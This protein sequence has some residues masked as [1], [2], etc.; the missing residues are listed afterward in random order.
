MEAYQHAD[1]AHTLFVRARHIKHGLSDGDINDIVSLLRQSL[2][3]EKQA[4]VKT[5]RNKVEKK[6]HEWSY[7]R[8]QHQLR[9]LTWKGVKHVVVNRNRN[10]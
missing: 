5:K 3:H 2:Y 8:I 10:V 6:Y 9:L 7:K 1:E 4:Y